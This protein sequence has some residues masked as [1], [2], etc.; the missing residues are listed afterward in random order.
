MVVRIFFFISFSD[1]G[2]FRSARFLVVFSNFIGL[3]R[4]NNFV[5]GCVKVD[6]ILI[7]DIS[8]AAMFNEFRQSLVSKDA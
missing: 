8:A 1:P 7:S 4:K 5:T 2:M 3:Q 6:F